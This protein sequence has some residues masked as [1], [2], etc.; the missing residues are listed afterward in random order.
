MPTRKNIEVKYHPNIQ[1]LRTKHSKV[2]NDLPPG[3]PPDC[4]IE[5]IIELEEGT[6]PI[7]I[8]P[9]CHP[10]RLKDEIEKTIQELFDQG[11][12]RP[13][14][15]PFASSVVL[16]KKKDGTLQMCIDCWMLNKRTIKNW[17]PIPRIDE[18]ID[19]MHGAK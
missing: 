17:Y 18:L 19:E 15:S 4:E 2:F 14:K 16:V 3:R 1:Q 10:K 5:H 9:Y 12:I 6:K 7:M 8:T 13:S 11:H